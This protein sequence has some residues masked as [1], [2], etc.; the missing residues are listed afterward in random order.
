MQM[1][2]MSWSTENVEKPDLAPLL[3]GRGAKA[4]WPDHG[5]PPE[6][7]LDV[8]KSAAPRPSHR[9]IPDAEVAGDMTKAWFFRLFLA[10][11]W[12]RWLTPRG[13]ISSSVQ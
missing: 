1:H 2:K 10:Q 11:N 13:P 5:V 6:P 9:M 3:N 7:T 12:L 8:G 4:V